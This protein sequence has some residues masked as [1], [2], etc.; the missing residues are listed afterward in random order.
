MGYIYGL[1]SKEELADPKLMNDIFTIMRTM[2]SYITIV[3]M[4]CMHLIGLLRQRKTY[5]RISAQNILGV[6]QFS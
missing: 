4:E 3:I 6:I 5:K 1:L 2:P